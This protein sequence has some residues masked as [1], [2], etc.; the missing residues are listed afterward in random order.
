[1]S[2]EIKRSVC[3]LQGQGTCACHFTHGLEFLRHK[4]RAETN[5]P[6]VSHSFNFEDVYRTAALSQVP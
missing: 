2:L 6:V 4:T 5:S 1:M 3:E